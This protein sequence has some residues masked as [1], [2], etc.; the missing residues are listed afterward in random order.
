MYL[1]NWLASMMSSGLTRNA[2][3]LPF[4]PMRSRILGLL[5]ASI[6]IGTCSSLTTGSAPR[7]AP[8]WVCP[9]ITSTLSTSASRRTALTAS[10]GVPALSP[11]YSSIFRPMMPPLALYSSASIW[12]AH[13][14][15]SPVIAEG[16]VIAEENPTLIGGPPCA[17]T[18]GRSP[19][20]SNSTSPTTIAIVPRRIRLIALSSLGSPSGFLAEDRQLLARPGEPADTAGGDLDGVLDLDAAPAMLVVGGLHAEDHAGLQRGVGRRVDGGWIVGL[21]PD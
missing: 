6:T 3:S 1:A 9:T 2:H 16:P 8:L 17:C 20:R 10:P 14:T 7:Q 11:K 18:P 12:A 4:L 21:E 13:F 15:P 5:H 19:P